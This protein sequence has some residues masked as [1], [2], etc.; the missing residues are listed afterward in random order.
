MSK[1]ESRSRA[2]Q[3][4]VV[5]TLKNHYRII[6]DGN[7]YS[8]EWVEESAKRGL[9]NF[10]TT[11]DAFELADLK[12]LYVP[13]G[14][15]TEREVDARVN[16]ALET[17]NKNMKIEVR[18]MI[19]MAETMVLPAAEKTLLRLTKVSKAVGGKCFRMRLEKLTAA[20][21]KLMT[22]VDELGEIVKYDDEDLLREAKMIDRKAKPLMADLREACDTIETMVAAED[23]KMATYHDLL[24]LV[25]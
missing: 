21:D 15:F 16:V 13:T 23:W 14:V 18:T 17:Y 11:P 6:F 10:K 22:S 20:A 5:E 12:S 7:G 24:F 8:P 9:L 1:G 3:T 2:V 4:V 19:A 25:S